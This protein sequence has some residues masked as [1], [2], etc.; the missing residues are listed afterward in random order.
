MRPYMTEDEARES[1]KYD[2]ATGS[3]IWLVTRSH[4]K[5]GDTAGTMNAYGYIQISLRRR[6][7]LAHRLAWE[8]VFGALPK[9]AIVHHKNGNKTDNRI[10]NLE[11]STIGAHNAH[12][13]IERG[14]NARG[15]FIGR[16]G[17]CEAPG[18]AK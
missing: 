18:G 5:R 6:L 2:P 15:Q 17:R 13:N 10:E 9:G 14:R 11:L 3:F 1:L 8:L 12:H 7:C 16:K 4:A